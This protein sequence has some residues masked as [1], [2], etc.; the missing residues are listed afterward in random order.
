MFE[1]KNGETSLLAYQNGNYATLPPFYLNID[2]FT[3]A[4]IIKIRYDESSLLTKLVSNSPLNQGLSLLWH[5]SSKYMELRIHKS[6]NEVILK[7]KT[8]Q[9]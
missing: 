9:T 2:N 4:F 6:S 3:W 1:N 7:L 5:K 8:D